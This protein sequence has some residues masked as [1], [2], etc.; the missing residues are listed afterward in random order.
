MT[1]EITP[2]YSP[3]FDSREGYRPEA[4]VIHIMDGTLEGTTDWFSKW[5]SKV[6]AHYGI[7]KNG[8]VCKYVPESLRAWHCGV[9]N[10]PSW[11][12]LKAGINPNF[13]TIGIEHEG[14]PTFEWTEA[15][16]I[17]SSELIREICLRWNIPIDRDH[18]IGHYEID[19]LRRPNCPAVNKMVIDELVAMARSVA[20]TENKT[21]Q[22]KSLFSQ[23]TEILKDL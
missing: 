22:L 19:S 3:N 11:K 14:T 13:Y 1:K 18:V 16:K 9:V 8:E 5:K 12:L 6:S 2:Q 4:I 7:G 17:S 20:I 10:F 15:T 23:G 21:R